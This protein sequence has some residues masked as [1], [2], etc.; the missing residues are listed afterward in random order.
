MDITSK[1]V[2]S[3]LISNTIKSIALFD[4]KNHQCI[5]KYIFQN[6]LNNKCFT[7]IHWS[8]D[9][10][11]KFINHIQLKPKVHCEHKKKEIL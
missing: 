7:A 3:L 6:L 2:N 1:A 9:H 4:Y 8:F 11:I 10:S 5:Y